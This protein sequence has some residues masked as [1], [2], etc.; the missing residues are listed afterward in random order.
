MVCCGDFFVLD[1]RHIK[2]FLNDDAK[3]HVIKHINRILRVKCLNL[4]CNLTY[5]TD[6]SALN[7][8]VF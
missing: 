3:L 5:A 1:L 2:L 6:C 4:V 7:W 8:T